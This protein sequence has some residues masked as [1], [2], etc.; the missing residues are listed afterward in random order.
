MAKDRSRSRSPRGQQA[1]DRDVAAGRRTHSA[2]VFIKPHAVTDGVKELVT[3]RL[4]DSGLFIAS[5]GSIAAEEIDRDQLIDTHYGAIA[6]KAVKQK[7]DELTV[8]AKAQEEFKTLFNISWD[9]ALKQ[10]LVFNALDGAK[11]LAVSTEQLGTMYDS[12]KKGVD[13]IKFGGGFY[14]GRVNGIFVINGFYM[15]MRSKFTAKGTCIYYYEVQWSSSKLSWAD[16]RGKVLGGTDPKAADAGSL[17]N[18]I[19]K[20]WR[21]L[22][23]EAEPN[24]GD[25]GMHASASPLE[26]LAERVNWL[27]RCL[28]EDPFGRALLS[29]GV[30][31]DCIK[32]WTDDPAVNFEGKKQSLFDLLED[33]DGKDCIQKSIE[34]A[35]QC[36]YW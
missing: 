12:L 21:K 8:Q 1:K 18:D 26:A 22:G 23:L 13:I 19:F 32:A 33:L 20:D 30:R 14:C 28:R 25:N 35:A 16:F 15:N 27:G 36:F 5:E 10:G 3:M 11:K 31:F 17:R 29:A 7:P 6:A 9:D 2:F 24:T 4:Q 34:I